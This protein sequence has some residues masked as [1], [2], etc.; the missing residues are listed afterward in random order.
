MEASK[1]VSYRDA[2][3][4]RVVTCGVLTVAFCGL[5]LAVMAWYGSAGFLTVITPNHIAGLIMYNRTQ[6]ADPPRWLLSVAMP[7][8]AGA[9]LPG[10]LPAAVFV[11]LVLVTGVA[12]YAFHPRRLPVV[13]QNRTVALNH[14]ACAP[15]AFL[16]IPAGAL[17]AVAVMRQMAL[18]E[19]TKG[20]PPLIRF[21]S[22][23]GW[24]GA[25]SIGFL[26]LRATLVLLRRT[27]RARLFKLVMVGLALPVAWALCAVIALVGVPWV[28]GL[29]RLM[30][31]SLG[32]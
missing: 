14:Y 17:V 32:S 20:F 13:L 12:S 2:L 28:A 4:F 9:T 24:A 31:T 26:L 7:W 25:I 16:P 29:V 5:L 27:T 11:A 21:L 30:V 22:I 15:L 1:P 23:V 10:V 6:V 8:E 3:R 19:P 18:D